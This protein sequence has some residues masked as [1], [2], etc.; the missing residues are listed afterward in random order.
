VHY[1]VAVNVDSEQKLC[2]VN[3]SVSRNGV[4]RNYKLTRDFFASSDYQAFA[5]F[6]EKIADLFQNG[7]AIQKGEKHEN[8][9]GLAEGLEWLQ[10]EA[11]RGQTRQRYKGLGE[12][13]PD[14]LWQTTMD[15][16]SRTMLRVTIEDAI[17]ADQVFT[18]LMGDQV[19][20]RREFIEENAL[21]VAN[22]DV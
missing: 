5:D 11:L 15:P 4:T 13:N 14:Q 18:T 3:V 20:P 16:A 7:V 10:T 22:L 2:F 6:S 12:M 21:A 9:A 8:V 19:E 17:A 1:E